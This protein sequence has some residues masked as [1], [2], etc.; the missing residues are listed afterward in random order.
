MAA[1]QLLS[2][3]ETQARI[4]GILAMRADERTMAYIGRRYGISR[5]RV[6]QIL[7]NYERNNS[8][9]ETISELIEEE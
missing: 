1:K 7:K 3:E 5:Q 8:E 2:P 9:L 6:H 4:E